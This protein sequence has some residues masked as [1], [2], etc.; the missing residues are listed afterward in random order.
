MKW[1]GWRLQESG[2]H[3]AGLR[4]AA[5]PQP[6]PTVSLACETVGPVLQDGLDIQENLEV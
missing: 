3:A 5:T 2:E 6:Q 4:E 1:G